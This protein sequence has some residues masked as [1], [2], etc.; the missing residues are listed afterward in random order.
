MKSRGLVDQLTVLNVECL[1]QILF[2]YIS[3]EKDFCLC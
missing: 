1:P 2:S 3:E